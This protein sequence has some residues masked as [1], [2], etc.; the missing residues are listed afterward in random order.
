MQV[1]TKYDLEDYLKNR[2]KGRAGE[3]GSERRPSG[4]MKRREEQARAG[5]KKS[6]EELTTD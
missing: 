6:K 1:K 3:E 4:F 2:S 5:K